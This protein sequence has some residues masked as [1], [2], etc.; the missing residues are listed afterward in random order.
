MQAIFRLVTYTLTLALSY[1]IYNVYF[2]YHEIKSTKPS[3]LND[4]PEFS[5]LY[6]VPFVSAFALYAIRRQI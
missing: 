4:L 2:V 6:W 3:T 1:L 5:K